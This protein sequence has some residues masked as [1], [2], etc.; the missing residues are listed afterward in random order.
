MMW[1]ITLRLLRLLISLL[2]FSLIMVLLRMCR[3]M[4]L[5]R[6][7]ISRR[8]LV[9]G[10]ALPLWFTNLVWVPCRVLLLVF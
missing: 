10:I 6:L 5:S 7:V 2:R 9:R 8:I 4:F 3:L 1:V